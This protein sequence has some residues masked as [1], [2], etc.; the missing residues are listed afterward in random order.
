MKINKQFIAAQ[1]AKAL[2]SKPG[3]CCGTAASKQFVF[4][5]DQ[6]E[7]ECLL[8]WQYESSYGSP[9]GQ[10]DFGFHATGINVPVTITVNISTGT[11]GFATLVVGYVN[12]IP[13]AGGTPYILFENGASYGDVN[14]TVPP[15]QYLYFQFL[16]PTT[17]CEKFFLTMNNITCS[18]DFGTS[19]EIGLNTDYC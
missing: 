7:I 6:P 12:T 15:N 1:G 5:T 18:E 10:L 2:P 8:N 4:P 16:D 19:P 13:T 11:G 14:I 3:G 9:S 17:Q